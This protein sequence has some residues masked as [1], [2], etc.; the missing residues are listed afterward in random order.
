MKGSALLVR[1]P[2]EPPV[3]T[4][5]AALSSPL[6]AIRL[7]QAKGGVLAKERPARTQAQGGVYLP[8]VERRTEEMIKP[9][10]THLHLISLVGHRRCLCPTCR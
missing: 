5:S 9:C 3:K 10:L 2:A 6:L 4:R 1:P 7:P 8:P